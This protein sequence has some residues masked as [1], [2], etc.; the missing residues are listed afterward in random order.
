MSRDTWFP[1]RVVST[2]A[3]RD[4]PRL[5]AAR[6]SGASDKWVSVRTGGGGASDREGDGVD[7]CGGFV[8]IRHWPRA[9]HLRLHL[10]RL[11]PTGITTTT[12][13]LTLE[14]RRQGTGGDA[15]DAAGL[16]S[17]GCARAMP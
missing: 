5:G 6:M 4:Q 15:I 2:R 11:L 8:Q 17:E 10:L 13:L 14:R 16:R 1:Y 12:R 9:R 7:T 3:M